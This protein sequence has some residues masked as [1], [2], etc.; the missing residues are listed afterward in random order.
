[1]TKHRRQA[2]QPETTDGAPPV[3]V[4]P[5]GWLSGPGL[6]GILATNRE[7]AEPTHA[8]APVAPAVLGTVLAVA[9]LGA[10]LPL[11]RVSQTS[12]GSWAGV[13]AA[14]E[15]AG[16]V[17]LVRLLLPILATAMTGAELTIVRAENPGWNVRRAE[18]GKGW[19]AT[20]GAPPVLTGRT[21]ES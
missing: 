12:A 1:V 20:R 17:R 16:L 5:G 7:P 14:T 13:R 8:G 9:E 21:L 2:R 6:T 11:W 4:D 18:Y 10:E 15:T 19:L 3:R